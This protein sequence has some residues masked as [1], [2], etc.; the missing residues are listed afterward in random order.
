MPKEV[1]ALA[2]VHPHDPSVVYFFLRQR[3]FGVNVREGRVMEFIDEV[4]VGAGNGTRPPPPLSW[5]SVLA[6][7][8]PPSLTQGKH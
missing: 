7:E 5:R 6:W 8:L 3:L 4:K 2:A 1:P